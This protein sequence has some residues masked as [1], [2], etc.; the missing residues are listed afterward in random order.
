MI[1]LY[2]N[3]NFKYKYIVDYFYFDTAF[4]RVRDLN[5][6]KMFFFNVNSLLTFL[7]NILLANLCTRIAFKVPRIVD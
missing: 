2:I 3:L 6:K 7:V 5:L 4:N 1:K